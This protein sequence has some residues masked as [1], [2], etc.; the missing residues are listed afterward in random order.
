MMT[1]ALKKLTVLMLILALLIPAGSAFADDDTPK[2][3]GTR[4]LKVG[5]T[6]DCSL[7]DSDGNTLDLVWVSADSSIAK[8]SENGEV[9]GIKAGTTIIAA[10]YGDKYYGIEVVV[11]AASKTIKLSKTKLT[12]TKGDTQKIKLNNATASKVK[13]SSSNKKVATVSS[14]GKIT[15]KKKGTATITAKYKSKKYKCKVTVKAVPKTLSHNEAFDKL[16]KYIK[17]KDDTKSS[18]LSGVYTIILTPS[19]KRLDSTNSY[20]ENKKT[21][22]LLS[23]TD[24]T[25]PHIDMSIINKGNAS[26]ALTMTCY[27][28]TGTGIAKGVHLNPMISAGEKGITSISKKYSALG[29]GS[30]LT[31]YDYFGDT[32]DTAYSNHANAMYKKVFSHMSDYISDKVGVTMKE[33]GFSSN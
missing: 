27:R 25:N 18:R 2:I 15:A 29:S 8:V 6:A 11:K 9:K 19:L 14:K 26:D 12:L 17:Q 4:S 22:Y 24:G 7:T 3:L 30:S 32:V 10:R 1:N 20:V 31:W 5:E 28:K 21:Y 33:L 16:A 23:Y 13:W